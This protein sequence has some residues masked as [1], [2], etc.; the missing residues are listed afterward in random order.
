MPDTPWRPAMLRRGQATADA[1]QRIL[2][3]PESDQFIDI[4]LNMRLD[5]MVT[6]QVTIALTPTQVMALAALA[7]NPPPEPPRFQAAGPHSRACGAARHDHG[8]DC[9]RNCPT[10]GGVSQ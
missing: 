3:L 9:N 8:P 6:A 5:E 7:A 2:N 1:V 10:C 4:E